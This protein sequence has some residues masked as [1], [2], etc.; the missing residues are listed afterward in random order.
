MLDTGRSPAGRIPH[1]I[2]GNVSNV[3]QQRAVLLVKVSVLST[4]KLDAEIRILELTEG[5]LEIELRSGFV[6]GE[7]R[8]SCFTSR[9]VV[10]NAIL[11]TRDGLF[12]V[13]RWGHNALM[14]PSRLQSCAA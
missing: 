8:S 13:A 5:G 10:P 12:H 7:Y 6:Q 2:R 9:Y 1:V 3:R 4:S 11:G 14:A